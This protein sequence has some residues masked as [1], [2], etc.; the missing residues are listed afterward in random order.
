M[1]VK[2]K[3]S[4]RLIC[5]LAVA[6]LVAGLGCD[7]ELVTVEVT[8]EVAVTREVPVIVENRYAV[9][10]TRVVD[11]EIPVTREVIEVVKI[12]RAPTLRQ[13]VEVTREVPVT[14]L[15]VAT[16]TPISIASAVDNE[17][18]T[19]SLPAPTTTAETPIP[20][21]TAAVPPT[22]VG[23]PSDR[24]GMWKL[25]PDQHRYGD[26]R[27]I[28]FHN[29]AAQWE[30]AP[31]PPIVTIQCDSRG[32]RTL[33]IDWGIQLSTDDSE[34]S[35]YTDDPFQQY[36]DDDLDALADLATH[37]LDFTNTA[38]VYAVDETR[39]NHIWRQLER[40]WQLDEDAAADLVDRIR[41]RNHRSVLI[42]LAFYLEKAEPD[43]R[44]RYGPA[45]TEEES[46]VWVVLAGERTH[47]Q[48]AVVGILKRASGP[49][50]YSL[51]GYDR[52]HTMVATVRSPEQPTA[53]TAKWDIGQLPQVLGACQALR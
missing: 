8:R 9:E 25:A 46:S 44:N 40:Q 21:P 2:R 23:T 52:L 18:P 35:R 5:G 30:S 51:V 24:F 47:A 33:Y 7:P 22:A 53:V 45:P 32:G 17:S 39:R 13:T 27:T 36:R 50:Y 42:D 4:I 10:V 48:A 26:R 11:R 1:Q 16:P 37:L 41:Q 20:D 12:T 34:F 15:V 6:V 19:D 29:I 14:R 43:P 49:N 3:L 28:R 38:K 31:E